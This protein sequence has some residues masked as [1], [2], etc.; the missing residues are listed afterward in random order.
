[1]IALTKNEKYRFLDPDFY[2]LLSI[3]MVADSCSYTIIETRTSAEA[4]EEF[5]ENRESLIA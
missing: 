1:M 2:K 5:I 3:L 4:R